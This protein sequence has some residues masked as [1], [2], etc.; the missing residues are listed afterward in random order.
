LTRSSNGVLDGTVTRIL[1]LISLVGLA[2]LSAGLNSERRSK[3]RCARSPTHSAEPRPTNPQSLHHSRLTTQFRPRGRG[4]CQF[5][6]PVDGS[7]A[8]PGHIRTV[9][10]LYAAMSDIGVGSDKATGEKVNFAEGPRWDRFCGKVG[11]GGT[12]PRTRGGPKP[13]KRGAYRKRISAQS[14]RHQAIGAGSKYWKKSCSVGYQ[15]RR[16]PR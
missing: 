1:L 5:A 13:G 2:G 14:P 11:R 16:R 6:C 9:C 10:P 15:D 3:R 7:L 8:R 12:K 4:V